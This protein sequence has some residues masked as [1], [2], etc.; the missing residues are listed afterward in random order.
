MAPAGETAA[1][2]RRL[3]F[4]HLFVFFGSFLNEGPFQVP[5]VV[6]HPLLKRTPKRDPNLE[7]YPFVL[8]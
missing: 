6:R 1:G 7:N 4:M 5:N 2:D 3:L 8:I